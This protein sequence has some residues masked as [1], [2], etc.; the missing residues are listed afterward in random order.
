VPRSRSTT[1]QRMVSSAAGL[2]RRHGASA[3]SIDRVLE[4]SGAPRGSV[5]HHFPGGRAQLVEEAVG[6][7]D[8]YVD[9]LL[10]AAAASGDPVA[11]VD[12]FLTMWREQLV[13]SDFHAGCPVVAVAVEANEEAPQLTDAAGAAFGHWQARIRSL[14]ADAGLDPDRAARVATL[15]VAAVEGALVLSRAQRRTDPLDD[16]AVELRDLLTA[17]LKETP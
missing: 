11:V 13:A 9:S 3:T 5:Y 6:Y 7:A 15:V 16:V 12:Q 4:V 17:A 14:L 2:I 10:D 8:R 1:R